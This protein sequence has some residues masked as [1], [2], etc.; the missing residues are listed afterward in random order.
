MKKPSQ[1]SPHRPR[2]QRR[3][4][5]NRRRHLRFLNLSQAASLLGI[6]R[7][8]LARAIENGQLAIVRIGA[9]RMIPWLAIE[10]LAQEPGDL[11]SGAPPRNSGGEGSSGKLST[12]WRTNLS[13]YAG[14][15]EPYPPGA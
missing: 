15:Q 9:R 3:A 8:R 1:R 12:D 2:R 10:R 14:A 4:R 11:R 7:H 6:C 5:P 13:G